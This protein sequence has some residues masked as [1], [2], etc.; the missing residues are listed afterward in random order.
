[1]TRN[2]LWT[3]MVAVALALGVPAL[4][5]G[6][7]EA[8][9]ASSTAGRAALVAL[10]GQLESPDRNMRRAAAHSVDTL[11]A[12]STA[13]MASELAR[14][15]P[16]R[17]PV[18]VTRLLERARPHAAQDGGA[19]DVLDGVLDL[20]P[21]EGGLAYAQVVTT[22]CLMRALAHIATPDAVLALAMV[23]MDSRG[24]FV[25]EV[26]R[27]L[28]GLGER[29]TAGLV[30][31]SHVHAAAAEKWAISELE[32]LG[33]RTP[34]DAVQTK[35]KEVLA[36]VLT[37]YGR[38][39]DVDA[40][41]VVMSFVNADRGLVRNAARDAIAAYGDPAVP[42]LREA[43]GLLVGEAA[44]NE[45]P[46][47]WLRR[48][49]FEALDRIRLEDVETR[50]RAGLALAQDG[51]FVEAVADFDDVLARQ[52]DWDK[53]GELVPAYVFYAQSLVDS[54]PRLARDMLEKA[55]RLDE[56]GPR[57]PQIQS[58]LALLEGKALERR[59]IVDEEPFRR[60]LVLDPGNAEAGAEV[61]RIED[62][63]TSRKKKWTR[64]AMEAS[65][66]LAVVSVL[67]LFT[68]KRRRPRRA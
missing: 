41:P 55:L 58:L 29:A 6:S 24:A 23:A 54:D 12:A 36:D 1:M 28:A 39:Q 10:L 13:S 67:I 66:A 49:L 60:A 65:G 18:E 37:A 32:T 25:L 34:G 5:R 64:R 43:Y 42:R 47:A 38:V 52:P 59:G 61:L 50:V 48:K 8:G 22:L 62:Q 31:M 7:E 68:G 16:G 53:K 3:G 9:T 20:S 21:A 45:W 4:A 26:R 33:T 57:V 2:A 44:P 40:L 63:A 27:R 56:S 15:R 17:P 35:S 51:R 19:D 14:L 46:P 30:L 11:G